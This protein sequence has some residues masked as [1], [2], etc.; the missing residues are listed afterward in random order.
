M[1]VPGLCQRIEAER[2]LDS[3]PHFAHP[4]R[5]RR[6]SKHRPAS[7]FLPELFCFPLVKLAG[8]DRMLRVTLLVLPLQRDDLTLP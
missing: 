5:E 2:E 7:L 1:Y 6:T 3:R 4:A 8:S